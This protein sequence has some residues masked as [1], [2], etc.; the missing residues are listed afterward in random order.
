MIIYQSPN[1]NKHDV[2]YSENNDHTHDGYLSDNNG[3]SPRMVFI[4]IRIIILTMWWDRGHHWRRNY[5]DNK[6]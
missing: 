5:K 6:H 2:Y 3:D 1:E 4:S